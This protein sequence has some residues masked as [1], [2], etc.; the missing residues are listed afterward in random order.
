M[1]LNYRLFNHKGYKG[2]ELLLFTK[3]TKPLNL[4]VFFFVTFVVKLI[5]FMYPH[6]K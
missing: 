6:L 5:R 3:T 2:L 4:C 1:E